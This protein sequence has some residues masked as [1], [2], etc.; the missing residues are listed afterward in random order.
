[1]RSPIRKF[2]ASS[3]VISAAHQMSLLRD[4]HQRRIRA[5]H[6]GFCGKKPQLH[7]RI[8]NLALG[9]RSQIR[10]ASA[11]PIAPPGQP[12]RSSRRCSAPASGNRNHRTARL[13]IWSETASPGSCFVRSGPCAETP[14]IT[15]DHA[16]ARLGASMNRQR[17]QSYHGSGIGFVRP[18]IVATP[19]RVLRGP[20]SIITRPS[21]LSDAFVRA[22]NFRSRSMFGG[23]ATATSKQRLRAGQSAGCDPP[24]HSLTGH[25]AAL[26]SRCHLVRHVPATANG[27]KC[28]CG[29]FQRIDPPHHNSLPLW[30]R[31]NG[32]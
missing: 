19:G 25:A 17:K 15:S 9:R 23:R 4:G 31:S 26:I 32:S 29:F 22:A 30:T 11:I 5:G 21:V 16:H 2:I 14:C 7:H 1:M 28:R 13:R 12:S 27:A 8:R 18:L 20:K 10:K 3:G 6:S 24:I